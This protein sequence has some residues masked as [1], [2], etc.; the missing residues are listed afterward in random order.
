[1]KKQATAKK[2]PSP[3]VF[4]LARDS[5]PDLQVGGAEDEEAIQQLEDVDPETAILSENCPTDLWWHLAQYHPIRAMESLLFGLLTL[6]SPEKWEELERKHAGNWAIQTLKGGPVYISDTHTPPPNPIQLTDQ[7]R[8]LIAVEWAKKALL[9]REAP[10]VEQG[11][12]TRGALHKSIPAALKAAEQAAF[13]EISKADLSRKYKAAEK[14][15]CTAADWACLYAASPKIR[16]EAW[17]SVERAV[18]GLA[19][20]AITFQYDQTSFSKASNK[21]WIQIWRRIL[22]YARLSPALPPPWDTRRA[23]GE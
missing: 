23:I 19:C 18:Y 8:R 7:A 3:K 10:Q 16:E 22:E 4:L 12:R 6:E 20:T 21:E 9:Q 2:T 13:G 1:M 11:G 14:H 17:S 5:L 15:P